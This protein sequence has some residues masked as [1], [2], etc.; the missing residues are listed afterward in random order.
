VLRSVYG[1]FSQGLEMPDLVEARALLA[2]ADAR[3]V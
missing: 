2:E 1:T 3:V